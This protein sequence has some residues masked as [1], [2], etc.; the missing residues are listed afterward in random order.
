MS[1]EA[2]GTVFVSPT[3]ARSTLRATTR[4]V[5]AAEGAMQNSGA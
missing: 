1:R 2:P 5:S 4:L 3:V